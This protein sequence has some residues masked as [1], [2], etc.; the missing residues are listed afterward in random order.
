MTSIQQPPPAPTVSLRHSAHLTIYT[1]APKGLIN[2]H[3]FHIVVGCGGASCALHAKARVILPGLGR[4]VMLQSVTSLA[5]NQVRAI[6]FAVPK[7]VR[8]LLRGYLRHHRSERMKLG[9]TVTMTAA[10]SSQQSASTTLGVWTLP[11]LR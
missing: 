7:R 11:D 3:H 4:T 6:S 1:K 5:A 2:T 9:V 10:G 8:A